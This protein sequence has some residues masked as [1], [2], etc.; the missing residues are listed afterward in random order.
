MQENQQL[1]AQN[2]QVQEMFDDGVIKQD[3]SGSYVPVMDPNEKAFIR[4][5]TAES[6]KKAVMQQ[7]QQQQQSANQEQANNDYMHEGLE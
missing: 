3:D 2:Q 4:Q 6:K 1:Q 7:N 5:Q